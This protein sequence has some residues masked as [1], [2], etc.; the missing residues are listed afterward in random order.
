MSQ[1]VRDFGLRVR[2]LSETAGRE[3]IQDDAIIWGRNEKAVKRGLAFLPTHPH[4]IKSEIVKWSHSRLIA[5][6]RVT[7]QR[8]ICPLY[9]ALQMY[10]AE[11]KRPILERVD[12]SG[13]TQWILDTKKA[14]KVAELLSEKFKIGDVQMSV[15][16][17]KNDMKKS[18]FLLKEAFERGYFDVPKGTSLRGVARAMDMPVSTLSIDVRRALKELVDEA[19]R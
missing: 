14:Y 18:V 5:R 17:D 15:R 3:E 16:A 10:S 9:A 2:L 19:T 7:V 11:S 4:V 6:V 8:Q 12:Y 1:L 13:K